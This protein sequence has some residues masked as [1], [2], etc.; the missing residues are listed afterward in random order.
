[1]YEIKINTGELHTILKE[2]ADIGSIGV[3]FRFKETEKGLLADIA[4][5]NNNQIIYTIPESI[6]TEANLHVFLE[7]A[8]LLKFINTIVSE[9]KDT[10]ISLE[11]EE[12]SCLVKVNGYESR[13]NILNIDQFV[14]LGS[15]TDIEKYFLVNNSD[16]KQLLEKGG[17]CADPLSQH[18]TAQEIHIEVSQDDQ[19]LNVISTD[20]LSGARGCKKIE[21]V[22]GTLHFTIT[23]SL[24]SILCSID[25]EDIIRISSDDK[26]VK[27]RYNNK[28][29]FIKK[30]DIE[31]FPVKHFE[32]DKSM[33]TTE[34]E[35]G[36]PTFI[37]H[38][39]FIHAMAKPKEAVTMELKEDGSI[40]FQI[41]Q[42]AKTSFEVTVKEFDEDA[43][44]IS[45][46]PKLAKRIKLF[47]GRVSI[48]YGD[49]TQIFIEEVV[50]ENKENNEENEIVFKY[51]FLPI[52]K[53]K[54]KNIPEKD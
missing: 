2:L 46:D 10:N 36:S 50:K 38:I 48:R 1:M 11:I 28:I 20:G 25:D 22:Q 14:E 16:F 30:R 7:L 32:F 27:I 44:S 54:N 17:I 39:N 34:I 24:A 45:F 9:F 53:E 12:S 40:K 52:R 15:V 13:I 31:K 26:L 42:Q 18:P 33:L 8:P 29:M 5:F 35:T 19:I 43:S 21:T 6:K 51:F 47:T 49:E 23:K 41:S 3:S 4:G 37:K